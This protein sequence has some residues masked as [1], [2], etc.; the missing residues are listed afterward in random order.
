MLELRSVFKSYPLKKGITVDALKN[1]SLTLP[2]HGLVFILG[3]SGA[4]KSTFLNLIGG[5]DTPSKGEILLDGRSFKDFTSQD[6]DDYRNTVLGFVFQEYNLLDHLNV[7]DNIALALSLQGEKANFEKVEE[8]LRKVGLTGYEKRS[9]NELSGGQKQRVAIARAL[10]KNPAILLADEPTGALDS[11]TSSEILSLLKELS[12]EKLVVVV[13]HDEEFAHEFGER[14]VTFKDGEVVSDF[15]RHDDTF[16]PT[17]MG[18]A[19]PY[20]PLP[21]KKG[22]FPFKSVLEMAFSSMKG[23]PWKLASS[24]LLVS[25]SFSFLGL[26]FT[27]LRTDEVTLEEEAITTSKMNALC[28]D[29][30]YGYATSSGSVS[31]SSLLFSDKD[32]TDLEERYGLSLEGYDPEK[33]SVRLIENYDDVDPAGKIYFSYYPISSAGLFPLTPSR[34]PFRSFRGVCPKKRMKC[35]SRHV[36]SRPSSLWVI[37]I[38]MS[39]VGKRS[40]PPKKRFPFRASWARN[41][42]AIATIRSIPSSG[43][44]IPRSLLPYSPL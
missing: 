9:V 33:G 2:N 4:G 17:V 18:K 32:K 10:I 11:E 28:F 16:L 21:L 15:S 1:V 34:L 29:K 22:V 20:E 36:N 19:T 35:S 8:V 38:S 43:W 24:L 39:R 23:K 44:W 42:M 25:L 40:R 41:S 6:Y 7:Q 12:K 13:S 5:L 37:L 3:K 30:T 26:A 14:I 27:C 31:T